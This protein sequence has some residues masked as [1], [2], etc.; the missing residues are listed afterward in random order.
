MKLQA[1]LR[2]FVELLN[3][4]QA[5]YLIVAGHAVA[6]H[7]YPRFTGG[8][9]DIGVDSATLTQ[10][11]NVIQLGRPPNRI[12][13][14]MSVSGLDFDEAWPDRVHAELDGL[15]VFFP[16]REA[17]LRNSRPRSEAVR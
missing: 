10:P 16:S 6:F 14:L 11:G 13:L 1:D 5:E 15:P 9:G 17:L 8:F 4:R 2:E 3:S 12:D 7:G